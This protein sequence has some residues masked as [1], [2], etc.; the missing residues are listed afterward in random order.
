MSLAFRFQCTFASSGP[1]TN[2]TAAAASLVCPGA[3]R[4]RGSRLNGPFWSGLAEPGWFGLTRAG[5]EV[6]RRRLADLR[7]AVSAVRVLPVALRLVRRL[8]S[9]RLASRHVSRHVSL[10]SRHVSHVLAVGRSRAS[11]ALGRPSVG[12]RQALGLS[13]AR[14]PAGCR[15]QNCGLISARARAAPREGYQKHGHRSRVIRCQRQPH[16][17]HPPA[18]ERSDAADA[19]GWFRS[20]TYDAPPGVMCGLLFWYRTVLCSD[21]VCVF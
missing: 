13:S 20:P 11:E 16:V 7:A 17:C 5:S 2:Q 8:V 19:L 15:H 4:P 1:G 21:V 14:P 6:A 18:E 9:S 3:P 10:V 12:P